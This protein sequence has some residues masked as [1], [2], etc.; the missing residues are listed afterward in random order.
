M[1]TDY[2]EFCAY[3]LPC[4]ICTTTKVMRPL[5]TYEPTC[6][7]S[8][9]IVSVYAAPAYPYNYMNIATSSDSELKET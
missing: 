8:P 9:P 4:G 1:G 2:G 3:R 7:N 5:V 6:G